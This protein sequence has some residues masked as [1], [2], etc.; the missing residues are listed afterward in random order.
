MD[1]DLEEAQDSM[2]EKTEEEVPNKD[3]QK[4]EGPKNK[5]PYMIAFPGAIM[6]FACF[7]KH[8]MPV[9]SDTKLPEVKKD[10]FLEGPFGFGPLVFPNLQRFN[11]VNCFLA[12]Y[13][14][15]VLAQGLIFGLVGLSIGHFQKEL[16][17]SM[18]ER[19]VLSFTYD[20]ISLLT[21]IPVAYYGSRWNRT[22][23]VATGAFLV[24]LG[25]I[26]C[27]VPY[28]KYQI[29]SPI[30][31]S[32]EL[33]IEEEDRSITECGE[34]VVPHRPEIV[35][36][37]ISG[38]C[39]QGFASMPIYILGVTFLYDHTS[40]HSA[41]IYLGIGEAV[42][43]LGYGL[44]YTVGSPNLKPPNNQDLEERV[45]YK[46]LRQQVIWWA[47]FLVAS[48]LS[49]FAFLPLLCFPTNLPGAH[50]LR[51]RKEKEAL[52]FDKR[53]K[54]KK[55]GLH[56]KDLFGAL[57]CLSKSQLLICQAMCKATESLSYIGA[58]EFLPKY[59]ENQFLLSPALA[60]LLTGIIL[61]PGGAIG[62]FLGGLIVSKLRMSVKSQMRF[63]MVTSI[64][65]LLLFILIV[66]I[67]CETVHF[68]GISEDYDGT[69]NLGNLTAPCN[70]HCGCAATDY[71]SV[72]GRD[73]TE[74]FS[75]CFA[76]CTTRK[77][78]NSEKTYYNCSCIKEGLT[79]A[80]IEGDFVDA[81]PGKCNTRCFKLPLFFAF[82]FSAI[83]FS[84]ASNIP[85]ILTILR[86]LPPNFKSLGMGVTYTT[87]RLF[88]SV[89]GPILFRITA[90][91]SC[92]YWD[93]NQCG[94]R[95][96]C[97]I[98]N[99]ARMVYILLGLCSAC[100]LAT[101]FLVFSAINKYD[102][103]VAENSENM[104][105]NEKKSKE[106]GET[107]AKKVD[108]VNVGGHMEGFVCR[109]AGR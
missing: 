51:H 88:G 34:S 67:E 83:A 4:S 2:E 58:T 13:C 90:N 3:Q 64:I 15:V 46:F 22:K 85:I 61:V 6:K 106:F 87:L 80:D 19:V 104:A 11:N 21:A 89:P 17:L 66:F 37:F 77:L 76:G 9:S 56:V 78:L 1:Q 91:S 35:S 30:E 103:I 75:P 24:G 84:S 42:Q 32:E 40:T 28:M 23:W 44:G 73:E 26:F 86:T 69:G 94:I 74:Y 45:S 93:I 109:N 81:F 60:T 43:I 8:K 14:M 92:I 79:T 33:C 7:K 29:V 100:K 20:F 53:L 49:W 54:F 57:Q 65:S 39:L 16:Y 50:K 25:A 48:L 70:K 95:G 96:R 71:A 72:C 97:W 107:K 10:A 101:T 5:S 12:V 105:L 99:K 108:L 47:S 63:I 18:P 55:F 82:F 31:D 62:S 38:Q 36:L 59:L 68:A 52:A 98:Y 41:G 27:A 102:L